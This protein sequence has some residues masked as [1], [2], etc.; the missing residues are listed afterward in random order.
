LDEVPRLAAEDDPPLPPELLLALRPVFPPLFEELVALRPP[1]LEAA[2][3]FLATSFLVRSL[4]DANPLF[5]EPPRLDDEL[6]FE[7]PPPRFPE[8]LAADLLLPLFEV[9]P[10]RPADDPVLLPPALFEDPPFEDDFELPF[11]EAPPLEELL[12]ADFE[13]LLPRLPDDPPLPPVLFEAL[14]EELPPPL[15]DAVFFEA[16]FLVAFAMINFLEFGL[17]NFVLKLQRL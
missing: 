11:D 15:V 2:P 3:P 7:E 8:L 10:P 1:P 5:D 4:A 14:F 12:E 13:L 17:I 6:P 16:A 9:A